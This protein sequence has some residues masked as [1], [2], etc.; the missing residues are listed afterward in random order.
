MWHYLRGIAWTWTGD[1][2]AAEREAKA[3][4]QQVETA[5]FTDLEAAGVPAKDVLRLAEQIV[6]ARIAQKRG[7]LAASVSHLEAAVALEDKLPYL[8][9]P[10]WYY[11][12]RQTLG[13]V[14][15]M[16]GDLEG[17]ADALR[18]SLEQSP[19]NGWAL[20][21]LAEV[22]LRQGKQG[23]ADDARQRFQRAW[24]GQNGPPPLDRL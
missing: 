24:L 4:A 8:E 11:P 22:Y 12:V 16:A 17:A 1:A 5:N 10:Y 21:G 15:L 7:D 18:K 14:R 20:F 3:I 6:R 13:G 23:E 9:P 2:A 19:H